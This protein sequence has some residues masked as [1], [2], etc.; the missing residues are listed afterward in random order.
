MMLASK[1]GLAQL[2]MEIPEMQVRVHLMIS[3]RVQGVGFRQYCVQVAR[4]YGLHGWVRNSDD[5]CVEVMAEGEK[6]SLEPFVCW[7]RRGPPAASV[8]TCQ[9]SYAKPTGTFDAFEVSF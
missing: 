4:Q 1:S 2:R 3:G 9:E 5:G 7:C 6:A 8:L